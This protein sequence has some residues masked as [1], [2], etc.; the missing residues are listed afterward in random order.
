MSGPGRA[1]HFRLFALVSSTRDAGSAI[2]ETRLLTKHIRWWLDAL[3]DVIPAATPRIELT[4]WPDNR[5]AHQVRDAVLEWVQSE[6][7][8]THVVEDSDRRHGHGY[9]DGVALRVSANDGEVELGDGGLT[10][11]TSLLMGDAKERCLVSCIATERLHQM[12]VAQD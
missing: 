5:V 10:N 8:Q 4:F 7:L 6:S 11:R 12:V 2:T 3:L 9:Y 1:A